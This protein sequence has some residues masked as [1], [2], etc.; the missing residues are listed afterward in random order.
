MKGQ[1]LQMLPAGDQGEAMTKDDFKPPFRTMPLSFG[2]KQ[3]S[4]GGLSNAAC[5][6][7]PE[8]IALYR[9][10]YSRNLVRREPSFWSR[11]LGW[12]RRSVGGAPLRRQ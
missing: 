1:N 4:A 2:A 5:Y 10:I 7:G 3:N 9:E 11:L 12:A 6:L 8:T